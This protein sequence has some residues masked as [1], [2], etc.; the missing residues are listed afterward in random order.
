MGRGD[1]RDPLDREDR[2]GLVVRP[3][4]RRQRRVGTQRCFELVRIQPPLA[5]DRQEGHLIAFLLQMGADVEYR[6]MFDGGRHDVALVG[7][8]G[9]GGANRGVVRLGA[10]AGEDDLTRM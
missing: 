5:V 1:F 7:L 10:A 3:H 9:E 8:S 2:A 6:R 4:D